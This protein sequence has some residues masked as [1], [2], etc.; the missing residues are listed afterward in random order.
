MSSEGSAIGLSWE[1]WQRDMA[2]KGRIVP[3]RTAAAT[4]GFRCAGCSA[5]LLP[6]RC[7]TQIPAVVKPVDYRDLR[8]GGQDYRSGNQDR[9]PVC[10]PA[11]TTRRNGTSSVRQ[12]L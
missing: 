3:E 11:F 10:S 6:R 2:T 1:D 7:C 12:V 8:P 9:V 5:E 4:W